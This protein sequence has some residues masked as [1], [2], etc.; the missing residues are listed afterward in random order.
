MTNYRHIQ[1]HHIQ[2]DNICNYNKLLFYK[3]ILLFIT[4]IITGMLLVSD[5]EPML[6]RDQSQRL[7]NLAIELVAKSNQLAGQLRPEVRE[8]IGD[9]VRSMNCYYSNL[10]EGHNTHPRD[11]DRAINDEYSSDPA[12]RVL[13][14][15]ARAHIDVQRM[16]DSRED[17]EDPP[18]SEKYSKWLHKEF[19]KR[20]P[21]ELLWVENPN[22]KKRV[23]V[24]PG[25]FR[26]GDVEIGR[27]IPPP[28]NDL[29]NYMARFEQ[30]YNFD[31]L[32]KVQRII[33]IA[34]AHH[35]FLW[36]HPFY[37][38]N[39]R[40]VRLMAHA[41]L[42]RCGVGSSI[43]SVARG[44]A[45]DVTTYKARLM[46]AD[47][48]R[49]NDYDGRGA[50]SETMLENFCNF[51]LQACIDQV[52]FMESLLQPREL[53]RRMKLYCDDEIAAG[54]LPNRSMAL[55]RE[56]LLMGAVERG[57]APEITGYQERRAREILST[58]LRKGLLVP[59][60]PKAP[61]RLGFP[62]DVVERWFPALYPVSW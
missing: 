12:K 5:M 48:A 30:V 2:Y 13:Q 16:I 20:L 37:D 41:M 51:F 36:I 25:E 34:A 23:Q 50:R 61:V 14:I 15:E 35:R 45:R 54:R 44:L 6:P 56:A 7:E 24:I 31:Q 58:L 21:D 33:A 43:W 57:K 28:A 52:D 42:L 18:T 1:R 3:Y 38:G 17:P 59:T 27:H 9:L 26:D 55:L 39:G 11:V 22:T 8:G 32:S 46:G 49:H 4:G 19:C 40:V 60:G 10:I 47:E 53:L 62:V 29:S